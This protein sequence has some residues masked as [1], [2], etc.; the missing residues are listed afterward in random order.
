MN[1]AP[2]D[3]GRANFLINSLA[4]KTKLETTCVIGGVTSWAAHGGSLA[5]SWETQELINSIMEIITNE[6]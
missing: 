2:F 6:Q 1:L 5:N 3:F 4:D